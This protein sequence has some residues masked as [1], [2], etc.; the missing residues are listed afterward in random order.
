MDFESMNVVVKLFLYGLGG[1]CV[2]FCI[3][4]ILMLLTRR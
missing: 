3:M 2:G 1:F 4:S